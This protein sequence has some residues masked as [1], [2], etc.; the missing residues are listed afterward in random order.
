[1]GQS[2]PL[3][4]QIE[5][6]IRR[7]AKIY[8][9]NPKMIAFDEQ[10]QNQF[11]LFP[12]THNFVTYKLRSFKPSVEKIRVNCVDNY[13]KELVQ[14]WTFMVNTTSVAPDEIHT[15]HVTQHKSEL[16]PPMP[17]VNKLN[18]PV[19]YEVE[20]ADPQMIQVVQ[21]HVQVEANAKSFIQL[22]ALGQNQPGTKEAYIYIVE[23]NGSVS[24]CWKLLV[25]I[26]PNN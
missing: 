26:S 9:D 4:L 5:T 18:M 25:V 17:F 7:M 20:S 19:T 1:M 2:L 8:S 12:G 22:R 23:S 11:E 14:G 15:I 21:K 24:L 16:L 3:R 6:S 10:Y 13:S